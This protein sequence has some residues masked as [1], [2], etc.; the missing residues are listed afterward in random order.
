MPLLILLE[1][2]VFATTL[3]IYISYDKLYIKIKNALRS[4]NG[5]IQIVFSNFCHNCQLLRD[6]DD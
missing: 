6:F 1:F 3:D 4:G 2:T 5:W